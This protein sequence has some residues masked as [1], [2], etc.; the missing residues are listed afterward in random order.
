M[1]QPFWFEGRRGQG[2]DRQQLN[3]PTQLL[4]SAT[5][6][7]GWQSLIH[8]DA[9][10]FGTGYIVG[11][12]VS[13]LLQ[14]EFDLAVVVAFVPDHVLE[15]KDGVVEVEIHWAAGF[16]LAADGFAYGFGALV[17]IG[18]QAAAVVVGRPFF[19]RY[20]VGESG[21]ILLDED[22]TGVVDV[23]EVL[24]DGGAGFRGPKVERAFWDKM[25]QIDEDGVVTVPGVDERVEER[26]VGGVGHMGSPFPYRSVFGFPGSAVFSGVCEY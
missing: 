18:G 8:P 9:P 22:Q 5:G 23:G 17:Q 3:R 13:G 15:K 2:Q 10:G 7:S 12:W 6:G 16:D 4:R 26:L 1:G 19:C 14:G 25:K 11:D 21:G 24:A 20:G